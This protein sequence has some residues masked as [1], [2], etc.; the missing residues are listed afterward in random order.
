MQKNSSPYHL[1]A[2]AL[3]AQSDRLTSISVAD[4]T[5]EDI[6]ESVKLFGDTIE[7]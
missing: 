3:L 1:G 4:G 2:I 5:I 7:I 6:V